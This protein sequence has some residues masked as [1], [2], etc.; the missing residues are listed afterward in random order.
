M[1]SEIYVIF[2]SKF[3]NPSHCDG[4]TEKIQWDFKISRVGSLDFLDL[5][6]NESPARRVPCPTARKL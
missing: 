4:I 5:K 1:I 6:V 3:D 2:Q